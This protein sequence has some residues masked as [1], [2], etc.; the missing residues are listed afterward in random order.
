ME[1]IGKEGASH[2]ALRRAAGIIMAGLVLIAL[3]LA[4]AAG[5]HPWPG[6]RSATGLEGTLHLTMTAAGLRA[7]Y[8]FDFGTGKLLREG[9]TGGGLLL[10]AVAATSTGD[11]AYRCATEAAEPAVCIYRQESGARKT[12]S[13]NTYPLK[14][15][16]AWSPDATSV[17]YVAYLD[18]TT[19]PSTPSP[20][21]WGVFLAA[22]DGTS[23][24]RIA[25]GSAAFFSPDGL[26]VYSLEKDGLHERDL[27]TGEDRMAWP[28]TGGFANRFMTLAVSPDGR[29]LAWSNPHS[30]NGAGTLLVYDI[31]AWHP[32]ALRDPVEL[33][34]RVWQMRFSPD[35]LAL[36]LV[37]D[38]PDEQPALYGYVPGQKPRKLYDL[39]AYDRYE[40]VLSD[41]R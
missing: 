20:D 28:V 17:L 1:N 26:S 37:A 5:V 34:L 31:A 27:T 24:R 8:V 6:Q 15:Y 35:S 30:A 33:P 9:R 41:W 21:A 11:V 4:L 25:T 38:G 29:Q 10:Q 32:L 3:A 22:A 13:G 40:T 18:T 19:P 7:P 12:V 2:R 23:D 39:S 36:A 14:R 16:L